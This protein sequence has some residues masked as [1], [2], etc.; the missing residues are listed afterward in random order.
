MTC[1]YC[2]SSKEGATKKCKQRS[3]LYET[4]CCICNPN[5]DREPNERTDHSNPEGDANITTLGRDKIKN[6]DLGQDMAGPSPTTKGRVGIYYGETSRSLFERASEHITDARKF[7]D[8]SHIMKH[9][10]EEHPEMNNLPE[11]RFRVIINLE[12]P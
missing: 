2:K 4:S 6:P 12:K 8:K 3:V 7:I 11:F 10:M 1:W 5:P 9:W